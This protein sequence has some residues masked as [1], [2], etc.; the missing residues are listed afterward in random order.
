MKILSQWQ[1][2]EQ[3]EAAAT[4]CI[5]AGSDRAQEGDKSFPRSVGL[6]W[7]RSLERWAFSI[8]TAFGMLEAIPC[9]WEVGVD[10]SS[11]SFL[12]ASQ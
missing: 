11:R 8:I 9:E 3:E 5:L 6:H 1:M 7:G 10:I 4:G 12:P 2:T